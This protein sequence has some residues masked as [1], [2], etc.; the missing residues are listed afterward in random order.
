[1]LASLGGGPAWSIVYC[2]ITDV[3]VDVLT[4]GIQVTV[5]ADGMLEYEDP[6]EGYSMRHHYGRNVELLFPGARSKVGR[7]F[8]DVSQFPVSYIRISIPAQ[9]REGVGILMDVV[10]MT[11]TEFSISRGADRQSV[12]ITVASS[13]TLEQTGTAGVGE[14][15]APRLEIE[16]DNGTCSIYAVNA[17]VHEVFARVGRDLDLDVAVD[18]GVDRTVSVYITDA[19]GEELL[20][21]IARA[22]GLALVRTDDGTFMISEGVVEDL[23]TYRLTETRSF[24]MQHT[25]AARASQLLPTFI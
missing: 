7:N 10:A 20:R 25:E 21:G 11:R 18:D 2:N 17:D 12:I 8:I 24:R 1:M 5:Q 4:N 22:A 9:A 15:G 3:R 16:T 19:T 6:E 14:A 23:A 13:R